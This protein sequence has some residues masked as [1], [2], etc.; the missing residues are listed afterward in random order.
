[1]VS[2]SFSIT[3]QRAA[4]S[5]CFWNKKNLANSLLIW[6]FII[7]PPGHPLRSRVACKLPRCARWLR[8]TSSV[9]QSDFLN[10]PPSFYFLSSTWQH[11]FRW[12]LVTLCL[13]FFTYHHV[14]LHSSCR[15]LCFRGQVWPI[16]LACLCSLG[17]DLLGLDTET[18]LPWQES[19]PGQ[20]FK[21]WILIAQLESLPVEFLP[22]TVF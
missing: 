15:P 1:M 11:G 13:S 3:H 19:V 12:F 5:L 10:Q 7:E 14:Y 2:A 17:V 16:L 6:L 20:Y 4:S 8:G 22:Q 21:A 18:S 9:C